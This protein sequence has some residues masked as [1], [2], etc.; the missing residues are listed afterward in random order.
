M[1]GRA[2]GISR[3]VHD[4]VDL[5][6][7][8]VDEGHESVA[9]NVVRGLDVV[10]LGEPARA[11]NALR[12][13]GTRGV[14][15]TIRAVNHLARALT[16][17]GLDPRVVGTLAPALAARGAEPVPMRSD[18][19]QTGAVIADAALGLLNGA[20]GDYLRREGSGLD[21]GLALRLGDA[22]VAPGARVPGRRVAVLVHGLCATEWSWC[23]RAAE[24][25]GDPASN[26]G[27]LLARDLGFTPL[28]AR[29]NSGVHIAEN[30]ARLARALADVTFDDDLEEVALLG[31]SMGGLVVRSACA[32]AA[33]EGLPWLPRVRR[34]VSLGSPHQGAPLEKLGH[35]ATLVLGAIDLPGTRIP[36]ELLGRRSAGIRDLRHGAVAEPAWL[37]RDPDAAGAAPTATLLDGIAYTFLSATATSDPTHPLGRLVG[38]LLVRVPSASGPRSEASSFQ[39]ETQTF[40]GVLHHE[41]QNHPDVYAQVLRAL[42]PGATAGGRAPRDRG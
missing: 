30:G 17:A 40:G 24:Y 42:G 1:S 12:R 23:L 4:A 34:V 10:G 2:R 15:D 33:R 39:I 21:L 35:W 11:V 36:A 29:Y 13:A 38:D 25:H 8:L 19:M 41:L 31:H 16:D 27:T 3:L 37:E 9:R 28:F 18:R 20:I 5:T 14:L 32:V 7:D 6:L 26:F 22:Y